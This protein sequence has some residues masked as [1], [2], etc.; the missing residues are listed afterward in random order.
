[1]PD[2]R[3]IV[4]SDY[5]CPWCVNADARLR[6]LESEYAGRVELQFKSF[7]LR[8]QPRPEPRDARHAAETLEKFR[9]YTRG[10]ARIA[11]E[12]D[13]GALRPWTSD[14]GPPSHSIPAHRA[15]KAAARHGR[16]AFRRMH[17]RL[18]RAYFVEHRDIS[19]EPVLRE[20]WRDVSLPEADFAAHRDDPALLEAVL[21]D[22]DEA[23][24]LGATGVP[25]VRLDGNEAVVVGAQ[26]VALYRRW[27]D[28]ALAR[29][30]VSS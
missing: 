30:A 24:R 25:A 26:P 4:Y 5:L 14:E 10:W 13:A 9:T 12:P 6:R 3:L 22:H 1:M 7:L 18:L 19:R 15:A 27:I 23:L 11:A 16:E 8:P 20:L 21:A 29:G 2:L 17:E 28:R